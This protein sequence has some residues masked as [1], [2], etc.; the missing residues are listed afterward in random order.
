MFESAGPQTR[1]TREHHVAAR[2]TLQKQLCS[3][4]TS[5]ALMEATKDHL[6]WPL[7]VLQPHWSACS[8]CPSTFPFTPCSLSLSLPHPRAF[9]HA[10]PRPIFTCQILVSSGKPA[11]TAPCLTSHRPSELGFPVP[12]QHLPPLPCSVPRIINY[13][14]NGASHTRLR[15][16]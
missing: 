11:Q 7:P 8:P 16:P 5:Q 12:S 10:S 3:G 13:L 2:G 6:R 9:A 14:G 1:N 15:A 4:I